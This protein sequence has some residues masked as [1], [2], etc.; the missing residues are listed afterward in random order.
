MIGRSYQDTAVLE[1]RRLSAALSTANNLETAV[2]DDVVGITAKK[3]EE[4]LCRGRGF[5]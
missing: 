4:V 5:H 1:D 2:M 3:T